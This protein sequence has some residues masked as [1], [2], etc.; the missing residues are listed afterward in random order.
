M[1]VAYSKINFTAGAGANLSYVH[2]FEVKRKSANEV[3]KFLQSTGITAGRNGVTKASQK[4]TAFVA[5][6]AIDINTDIRE[7]DILL[8]AL[9]AVM[10]MKPQ[11]LQFKL[12]LFGTLSGGTPGFRV[13][14]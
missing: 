7:E 6:S 12:C 9:V 14:I 10:K 5:Q 3:R 1:C 11:H 4:N 8:V 13:P 2:Q